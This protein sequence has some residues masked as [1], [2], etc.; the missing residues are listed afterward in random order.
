MSGGLAPDYDP[1]VAQKK[2]LKMIPCEEEFKRMLDLCPEDYEDILSEKLVFPYSQAELME[3][4]KDEYEAAFTNWE[5]KIAE[6]SRNFSYCYYQFVQWNKNC[7]LNLCEDELEHLDWLCDWIAK[8][9]VCN[10][11]MEDCGEFQTAGIYF[12]KNK[13]LV[14]FNGR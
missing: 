6:D 13:K 12:N 9:K 4:S 1:E 3:M 7:V 5:R 2:I 14:I 10:V 8:D 11:D